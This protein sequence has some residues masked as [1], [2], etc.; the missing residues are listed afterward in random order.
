L[1]GPSVG[2]LVDPSVGPLVHPSVRP[3]VR[4]FSKIANS[5][6]FKGIE[7]TSTKIQQNLRKFTTFHNY[8]P[9]DGLFSESVSKIGKN[10]INLDFA[11]YYTSP[12]PV[13]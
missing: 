1:V 10:Q 9:G 13:N 7:V 8:W 4:H 3:W 5:M 12:S 11:P 6:K 2:L